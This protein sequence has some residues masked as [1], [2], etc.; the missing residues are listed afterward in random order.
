MMAEINTILLYILVGA[1]FG[2]VYGLRRIYVIERKID[3]IDK[4]IAAVL[5]RSRKK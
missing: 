5:M 4:K 2:I 3:A 1:I